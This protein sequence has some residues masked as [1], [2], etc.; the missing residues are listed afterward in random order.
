[1]ITDDDCGVTQEW[2]RG[3]NDAKRRL[4]FRVFGVVVGAPRVGE[5]GSVLEA[6]CDNLRSVED[7]TDVHAAADLFR[8]I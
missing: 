1:M 4:G 2:T 8:V 7:L 3:W 5:A 6:L